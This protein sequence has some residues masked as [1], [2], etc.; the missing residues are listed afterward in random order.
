MDVESKRLLGELHRDRGVPIIQI[1]QL[2]SED[3]RWEW[4]HLLG[5]DR[6]SNA[7]R[8]G[9]AGIMV[10]RALRDRGIREPGVVVLG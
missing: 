6:P 5:Y 1:N 8:A 10:V 9:N 4:D 2:P 7:T 3:T